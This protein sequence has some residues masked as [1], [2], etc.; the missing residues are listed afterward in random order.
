MMHSAASGMLPSKWPDAMPVPTSQAVTGIVMRIAHAFISRI[1]SHLHSCALLRFGDGNCSCNGGAYT[2]A[3]VDDVEAKLLKPGQ[4][5]SLKSIWRVTLGTAQGFENI[6]TSKM[7]SVL[8]AVEPT[9]S[10]P[11]CPS[12]TWLQGTLGGLI[13]LGSEYGAPLPAPWRIGATS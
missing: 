2:F 3:D 12:A 6:K 5:D 8:V 4:P 1:N 9:R 10:K 11:S 13:T 7:F